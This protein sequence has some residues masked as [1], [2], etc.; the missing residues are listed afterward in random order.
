MIGDKNFWGVG[1]GT[2][3]ISLIITIVKENLNIQKLCA[4]CAS[5]I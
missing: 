3:V 2:Y 1:V 4:S 5:K